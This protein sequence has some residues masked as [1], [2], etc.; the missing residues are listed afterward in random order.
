MFQAGALSVMSNCDM[1][2]VD[3]SASQGIGCIRLPADDQYRWLAGTVA[4]LSICLVFEILDGAILVLV[5]AKSSWRGNKMKRP[6]FSMFAGNMV[7]ICI[8][9]V[10][11]YSASQLPRQITKL[12]WVFR[13]EPS[14]QASTVCIGTLKSYGVRGSIIGWTDG[15]LKSWGEAY[16]GS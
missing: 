4:V 12:V 6:W 9:I 8:L 2:R 14:I 16:I 1:H 7:L 15:F 11:I 13:Y 10:G 5:S 3:M